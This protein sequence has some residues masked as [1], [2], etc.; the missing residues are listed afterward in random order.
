M[1][2]TSSVRTVIENNLC[3]GCGACAVAAP[4][5]FSILM[6][7]AGQ[8]AAEPLSQASGAEIS[9]L[10]PMSGAGKDETE[11]A[12]Q[13]YPDLPVSD[14]IGRYREIRAGAVTVAD[15]REKG[16]SGGM[17]SWIATE[18]MRQGEVDAVVHVRPCDPDENDG[19]LFRYAISGT[20]DEVR[21]GAKS[22]YYPITLAEVLPEIIASDKR[23]CVV[24]LP[25]F[26]K[27]VRLLE[28]EGVIPPGRVVHTIGLV[29][30]H[31]KSRYFADYLARQKGAGPGEVVAFDF[32]HK[33]EGRAAS[34][35]G[36]S[37]LRRGE[38][39][40]VVAPMAGMSAKDW[41]EGQFKYPA[42]E[43]C[44]DVIAECADVVI[45]DAWLPQYRADYRGTNI[46]VSRSERI[47]QILQQGLA[48]GAITADA[49][50]VADV[51]ASQSSGLR[52]RREGLAHRLAIRARKGQWAPKK[53]VAPRVAGSLI[54]RMVYT[55]RLRLALKTSPTYARVVEAGEPISTYERRI[56]PVLLP[57][58]ITSRAPGL[59]RRLRRMIRA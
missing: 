15:F 12:T 45:G 58:R 47:E 49:L 50:G 55:L 6:N 10:C 14:E 17:G 43:Y 41:G 32:R 28:A 8:F 7:R 36:F 40:P 42:C 3:V 39:V 48:E 1:Q 27:S 2:Q 57:Y 34:D 38:T 54:R 52:H 59:L 21:Q 56:A 19:L 33:L 35:Y 44:D 13:L 5:D 16:G 26:I 37:F 51:I 53:R 18:L 22:R 20:E 25:C 24:G 29:C 31:L 23:Y 11:I 30:G 9:T 46:V 4:N